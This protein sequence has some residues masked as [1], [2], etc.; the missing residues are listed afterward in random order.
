MYIGLWALEEPSS[1]CLICV[2]VRYFSL[3]YF[4][5]FY[6]GVVDSHLLLSW[7]GSSC[8]NMALTLVKPS[9]TEFTQV[10]VTSLLPGLP[11]SGA[12]GQKV[13]TVVIKTKNNGLYVN[14]QQLVVHINILYLCEGVP[15][16]RCRPTETKIL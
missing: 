14:R 16:C 5:L 12:A 6:L 13:I 15:T 4:S 10:Q 8:C 3:F 1:A 7:D 9:V 11:S 2:L